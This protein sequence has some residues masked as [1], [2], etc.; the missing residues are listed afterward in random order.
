MS[1][2]YRLVDKDDIPQ[3]LHDVRIFLFVSFLD[4]IPKDNLRVNLEW[5]QE[6][7]AERLAIPA[8]ANL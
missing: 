4:H 6:Y 5:I 1:L 3:I 8:K 7:Q 2:E